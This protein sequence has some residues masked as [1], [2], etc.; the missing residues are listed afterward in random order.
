MMVI[1]LL[2]HIDVAVIG[3]S[4]LARLAAGLSS[5]LICMLL[6]TVAG[7]L[8]KL[9]VEIME[10]I[11]EAIG[12]I[13]CCGGSRRLRIDHRVQADTSSQRRQV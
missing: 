7:Q 12:A 3:K 8:L 9:V 11:Y 6:T 4:S 5:T 13:V 10:E 1:I 2:S